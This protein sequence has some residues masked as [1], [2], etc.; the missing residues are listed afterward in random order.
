MDGL[1]PR[2]SWR[3]RPTATPSDDLLAAGHARGMSNRL[4]GILAARGHTTPA[5][6]TALL[7]DPRGG[8]HDPRLLPDAAA[9][10]QRVQ[11]ALTTG[12]KVLVF[13]DFDAD[14]LTGLTILALALR[15]MGLEVA[16]Y[17]PDRA[18]EGHGLSLGAI[19]L[20]QAQGRTLII[21]ADCGTSSGPEIELAVTRGIDVLVT[22]HHRPPPVLPAAAAA[23]VNPMLASS[24]YPD[25]R[26]CGA[27]VALKVAQLLLGDDALDLADL[28]AIG[29]VAD[30]APL[31][32]ENRAI[33]RLGLDL[34][35]ANPRPGLAALLAGAGL[36]PAAL[37]PDRLAFAVVPRINA[38]GRVGD[39]SIAARLLGCEDAEEAKSLAAQ[40]EAANVLRRELMTTALADARSQLVDRVLDPVTILHGPWPVGIVGLIAGRLADELGRPAVVFSDSA[41]PWRGSARAGGNFDLAAALGSMPELFVRYGGHS[42]AA[43]CNMPAANLDTFRQRMAALAV[44]LAPIE[45]ALELDL[46]AEALDVDYRLLAELRHLEPVGAGNPEPLV[47]IRGLIPSR[48]RPANGGHTQ[49]VL[50]KGREVI[51]GICFG[52]D[53]LPALIAEGQPIDIV[54][55]LVSRTFGGFESLQLDVRDVAPA[56]ALDRLAAPPAALVA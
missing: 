51:D 49:L 6:W 46:V 48:V 53:D 12:E 50:R 16:T 38:V 54:A 55:R 41:E 17:V 36:D 2:Y 21:T 28:A 43:G 24:R 33:V 39:A 14:G 15:R 11:R 18:D 23:L 19:E 9:L 22:D 26:L 42:A 44:D 40:L 56:G 10:S 31:A 13:G 7:D 37:D 34:L 30:V 29:T 1:T 3:L 32:G 45:P 35:R 25:A 52:R 27:G 8:L 47:G 20:A 5:S 4:V